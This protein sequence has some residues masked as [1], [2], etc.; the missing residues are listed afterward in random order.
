VTYFCDVINNARPAEYRYASHAVNGVSAPS[1]FSSHQQA[2]N[3]ILKSS[4]RWRFMYKFLRF[5]CFPFFVFYHYNFIIYIDF[6]YI[7][8]SNTATDD[9]TN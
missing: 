4:F 3:S 8:A 1:G 2:V 5:P 7:A 9:V 6:T